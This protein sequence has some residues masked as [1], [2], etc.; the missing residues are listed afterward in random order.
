MKYLDYSRLAAFRARCFPSEAA[1][2]YVNVRRFLGSDRLNL[3]DVSINYRADQIVLTDPV[4]DRFAHEVS[5]RMRSEGRLY[6]GPTVTKLVACDLDGPSPGITV[7]PVDYA[8]QAGTCFALDHEH[9]SFADYG[10]TLRDYYRH[11]CST[12]TIDNNPLAICIGVSGCLV[13][14]ERGEAFMLVVKRSTH[15]ASLEGTI[16]PSVAGVVDYSTTYANL[17][18]LNDAALGAEVEEELNLKR[19]EFEIVPLAWGIELFRG[20][21]PQLFSLVR[22]SLDRESALSR[23]LSIPE[24]SREFESFEFVPLGG[25]TLCQ[26]AIGPLNFEARMNA[27]LVGEYQ[28]R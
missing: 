3:A 22:T 5:E 18:E 12:P 2:D 14:E 13:I 10:G 9:P 7:Q 4:I 21:R 23:L 17:A 8:L 16:G 25:D 24:S 27:L 1:A 28:Q 15:L 26:P 19:D 11:D 6:D 20:E